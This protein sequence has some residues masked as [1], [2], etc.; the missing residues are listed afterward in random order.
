MKKKNLFLVFGNKPRISIKQC[1]FI[2]PGLQNGNKASSDAR[3]KE[4]KRIRKSKNA[5]SI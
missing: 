2:N 3:H 4:K 1:K 5:T